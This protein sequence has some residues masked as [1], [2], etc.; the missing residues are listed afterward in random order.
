MHTKIKLVTTAA[1]AVARLLLLE[2]AALLLALFWRR[3]RQREKQRQAQEVKVHPKTSS[4]K[5]TAWRRKTD[6]STS[7][8]RRAR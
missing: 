6:R 7:R 5:S 3:D 1:L 2:M 4:R 8:R